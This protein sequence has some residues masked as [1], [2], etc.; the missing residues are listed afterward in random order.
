[1]SMNLDEQRQWYEEWHSEGKHDLPVEAL[2]QQM[3]LETI[4]AALKRLNYRRALVIGCGSGDELRLLSAE[5]V[6]AFDLSAN[7]VQHARAMLPENH[8]LQADGMHL[9]FAAGSFDL[10]LTSEVIEH[11]LEPEKMIAEIRRVL[12]P[13]GAVLVTT[14]NWQSFF[15]LARFAAERLLRRP[16]TSDDQPVDHWST[17]RSLARLLSTGGLAPVLRHGAWYFPPTGLGMKRLP[18]KPMAGLFRLLLPVERGLRVLLP[19]WG[20]LLVV[21]AQRAAPSRAGTSVSAG[22]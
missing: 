3:R 16:V 6:T 21:A 9:P 15:G 17:P 5:R 2:K 12:L 20:H 11:I 10:V 1:M 19:G 13:G 18:D 7:A 22:G 14:P 4:A 8:Y